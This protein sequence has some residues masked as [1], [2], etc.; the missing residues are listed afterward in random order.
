MSI[1]EELDII[2][3]QVRADTKRTVREMK[4]GNLELFASEAWVDPT[5]GHANAN[6]VDE[7][8]VTYLSG[9]ENELLNLSLLTFSKRQ[10]GF[11]AICNRR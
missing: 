3:K 5:S 6:D 2:Q 8:W 9:G 7:F 1:S 10:A 11:P 4:S